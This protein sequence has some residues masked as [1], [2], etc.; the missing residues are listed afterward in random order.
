M[1]VGVLVLGRS[2]RARTVALAVALAGLLMAPAVW[3]FDTLSYATSSTF[4]SGG[5]ASAESAGQGFGPGAAGARGRLGG[6]FGPG[7]AGAPPAGGLGQ[8]GPPPA[9]GEGRSGAGGSGVTLFGSGSNAGAAASGAGSARSGGFGGGAGL[10]GSPFGGNAASLNTALSYIDSHGGGTLAVSSQSGAAE[11]II[12]RGANVVGIGGFSGRESE[13]TRSWLAQ[14]VRSGK[15]RW[16]LDEESGSSQ[17]TGGSGAGAGAGTLPGGGGPF[18][19]SSSPLLGGG[20]AGGRPG[21]ETR[22]G[23]KK[24]MAVVAETCSRVELSG[25]SS[26]THRPTQ[27]PVRLR[28]RRPSA[29]RLSAT[30]ASPRGSLIYRSKRGPLGLQPAGD[31]GPACNN[32]QLK[33]ATSRL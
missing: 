11:A 2:R 17:R 7:G 23:A 30:S 29:R 9:A 24:V 3:A 16:V 19:G 18:G 13:V 8:G 21:G 28:R 20:G 6:G 31:P 1:T 32:D 25:S 10:G 27:A 14:E 5:P 33:G 4:P 15:I 12:D 26:T 22:V